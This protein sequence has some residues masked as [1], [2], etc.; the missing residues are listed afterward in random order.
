MSVI[1]VDLESTKSELGLR[2]KRALETKGLWTTDT[3]TS[4][5]GE[6]S[7]TSTI[8]VF[9]TLASPIHHF[10]YD[11]LMNPIIERW[12]EVKSDPAKRQ[13][14]MLRRQGRNLP[15]TIPLAP[16]ILERLL[17]GWY[18]GKLLGRL[19][20][21]TGEP[22]QGPKLSV[23]QE[24]PMKSGWELLPYPL[25]YPTSTVPVNDFP[26]VVA[27][28]VSIALVECSNKKSM[29]PF[30]PYRS[31]M[32]LGGEVTVANA[33][34]NPDG[35][36][37]VPLTIPEVLSEWINLGHPKALCPVPA[38]ERAGSASSTPEARRIA[39]LAFFKNERKEFDKNCVD[40]P[41]GKRHDSMAWE[42]RREIFAAL[43]ELIR[44]VEEV[45]VSGSGV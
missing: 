42:L 10:V 7:G 32:Q 8:D 3:A 16:E 37:Q 13:S 30:S 19:D 15:E 11:N 27:A 14:F 25:Y 40:L 18:V 2:L 34:R 6:N 31:L 28:S 29:D 22:G 38:P 24:D 4:F 17:R 23:F 39:V 1:P 33:L 5:K 26:A 36:P 35:S 20:A 43:D 45:Q 44:M 21:Q 12:Q 9:S 41:P